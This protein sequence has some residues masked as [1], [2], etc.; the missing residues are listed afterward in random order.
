MAIL[1]EDICRSAEVDLMDYA[2]LDWV[3]AEVSLN[4]PLVRG[5]IIEMKFGKDSNDV[6]VLVEFRNP[7]VPYGEDP[8]MRVWFYSYELELDNENPQS[9]LI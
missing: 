1:W 8:D 6:E 4:G 2:I 7:D 5:Q 3:L 9:R